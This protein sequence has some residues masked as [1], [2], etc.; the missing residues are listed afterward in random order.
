MYTTISRIQLHYNSHASYSTGVMCT[1]WQ[2]P[3]YMSKLRSIIL[4]DW[5]IFYS[6]L[7]D[8]KSFNGSVVTMYKYSTR[9]FIFTYFL[10]NV[11]SPLTF[12]CYC[13]IAIAFDWC[14]RRL[15]MDVG[16]QKILRTFNFIFLSGQFQSLDFLCSIGIHIPYTRWMWSVSILKSSN[17]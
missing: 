6:F 5:F 10:L 2:Q 1:C 7:I 3:P 17:N 4:L 15:T 14:I 11:S 13:A 9:L 8:P 16:L 12:K